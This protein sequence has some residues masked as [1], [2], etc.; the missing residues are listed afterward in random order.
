MRNSLLPGLLAAST[1]LAPVGAFAQSASHDPSIVKAGKYAIEPGH[2]QIEFTLLHLGFSYYSGSFSNVSGTAYLD[3][4]KPSA[5]R[6]SVTIP[7]DSVMTTSTKL[8]GELKGAEWFDAAKYPTATFVS[9]KVVPTGK[10]TARITGTLTLH[11]V[12]KPETLSARFV[13][14]G[15][16]PL[17]KKYTAGFE[18][19]GTIRRS[20]YGVKTYVPLV[21]DDVKL[22]IAGAFEQQG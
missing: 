4:A 20:D 21:G 12:S 19:T 3:P 14:A 13:G 17:D 8:D 18:V 5:D 10:D 22:T 2:T 6:L 9:T 1:L 7:I 15:V 16:N 11:G